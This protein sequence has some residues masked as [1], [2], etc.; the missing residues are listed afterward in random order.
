MTKLWYEKAMLISA[1]VGVEYIYIYRR[2]SNVNREKKMTKLWYEKAMLISAMVGVEYIYIYIYIE[3]IATSIEKKK[4]DK[5]MI[6]KGNVDFSH[7]WCRIYIYIEK[8]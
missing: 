8:I 2:Y 7:G 5:A 4:N 6:W 3:D 1:M